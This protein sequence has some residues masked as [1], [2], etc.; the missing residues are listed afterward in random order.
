M[1]FSAIL[2]Q[3]LSGSGS[4]CLECSEWEPGFGSRIQHL[5]CLES[6]VLKLLELGFQERGCQT[7]GG[8]SSPHT[9]IQP[10]GKTCRLYSSSTS[11][12]VSH[13]LPLPNPGHQHLLCGPLQ[14][15]LNGGLLPPL[16][17]SCGLFSTQKS[18]S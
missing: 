3:L 11:T 1:Y 17:S 15:A 10:T 5:A 18:E 6:L 4:H 8:S 12:H 14:K 16:L 7:E 13:P 9:H 2:I